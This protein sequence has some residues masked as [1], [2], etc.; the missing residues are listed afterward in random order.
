MPDND[1]VPFLSRCCF[2]KGSTE[3]TVHLTGKGYLVIPKE[4][5][6][7]PSRDVGQIDTDSFGMTE[8]LTGRG[9]LTLR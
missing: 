3:M 7:A 4:S 2:P 1:F 8:S 9:Y 5:F 6:V